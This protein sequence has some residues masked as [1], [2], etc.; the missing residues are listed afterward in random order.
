MTSPG[1]PRLRRLIAIGLGLLVLETLGLLLFRNNVMAGWIL[2]F[3]FLTLSGALVGAAEVSRARRSISL[4]RH[5]TL[6]SIGSLLNV[7]GLAIRI[8][9]YCRLLL[10]HNGVGSTTDLTD[11]I[12]VLSYVPDLLVLSLPNGKPYPRFFFWIDAVQ[13]IVLAYLVYLKLFSV[14]PFTQTQVHPLSPETMAIFHAVITASMLAG[15]ILRYFGATTQDEKS[16]Y[17]VLSL[18]YFVFLILITLHNVV[19]GAYETA[20][21][22]ELLGSAPSFV[23]AIFLQTLPEESLEGATM[24][25][26]GKIAETLNNISPVFLTLSLMALG[27]DASRHFFTFGMGAIAVAFVLHVFRSTMLQRI[28]GRSQNSLQEARDKLEAM[29]L[30]D[31]LTGVANRRC[32]DGTLK[33]EW[34][35]AVRTEDPISL[36]MMDIDHFK[37]LNDRYGHQTGDDCI[38]AV[39]RALRDCLPRSGDLL[40]RYGGEEFGVILPTTDAEGARVVAS[41]MLEAVRLLAIENES[42][43]GRYVTIS[44]GIATCVFPPESNAHQL[45]EAADRALYRAKE[46]GRNRIEMAPPPNL[47]KYPRRA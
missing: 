31:A 2:D 47:L 21:L 13:T 27:I 6:L 4:R 38:A 45:L 28:Y 16:F 44:A 36:L 39:A 22:Y 17:R 25:A 40:A 15:M 26:P 29:T 30:T 33:T 41:K 24:K 14:I 43:I 20:T 10:S 5:W 46:N 3:F 19:A 8:W 32:F 7:L 35:R 9:I 1:V 42:P 11:L 23:F 18:G 34:N 12:L 37:R